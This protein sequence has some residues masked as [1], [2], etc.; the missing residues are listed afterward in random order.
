MVL[1]DDAGG[2]DSKFSWFGAATINYWFNEGTSTSLGYRIS[3]VDRQEGS[4]FDQLKWDT[5]MH[6]LALG[7]LFT[8]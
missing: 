2:G 6:D 4:G 5:T 8:F 1:R 7:V 3:S